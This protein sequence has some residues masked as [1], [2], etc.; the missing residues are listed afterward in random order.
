MSSPRSQ[1][2]NIL[3]SPVGRLFPELLSHIFGFCLPQDQYIYPTLNSAPW[4]LCRVCGHWRSI[5]ISTPSLWSS[6]S[7]YS[8]PHT[9]P[10]YDLV[11][12][13]LSRAGSGPLSLHF[14]DG[15]PR[16]QYYRPLTELMM[17]YVS[18]WAHVECNLTPASL[19]R[20]RELRRGATPQLE[21][22]TLITSALYT[23]ASN[24]SFDVFESAPRLRSVH[25]LLEL[26][27]RVFKLPLAQLT[28]FHTSYITSVD[29]WLELF[30]ELRVLAKCFCYIYNG[31]DES[32]PLRHVR[33]L[34][35]RS[36][37]IVYIPSVGPFFDHLTV[38]SLE[39]LMIE[40]ECIEAEAVWPQAEFMT[41]L[42]PACSSS[43]LRC[44]RII[45]TTISAN[46]IIECLQQSHSLTELWLHDEQK[47]E[48]GAVTDRLLDLLTYRSI[49]PDGQPSC[50]CPRL[51]AISFAGGQSFKD[52]S[53]IS[54]AY[55][56]RVRN[57]PSMG[58]FPHTSIQVSAVLLLYFEHRSK[59]N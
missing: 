20:L 21:S 24:H 4:V 32:L 57:H 9:Q 2:P 44:L 22:F 38:P 48:H 33:L 39:F 15:T 47:N 50:L 34:S 7:T 16:S 12:T 27:P 31:S 28:D 10:T 30:N 51:Q 19:A 56:R 25:L 53:I 11:K 36:L 46:N 8:L 37:Q 49:G 58:S 55:S 26:H 41:F 45:N 18:S 13:W 3:Q 17:S 35:L 5:A 1:L 14:H 43:S 40:D 23:L 54:L 59:S 52:D 29:G 42:S 6:I